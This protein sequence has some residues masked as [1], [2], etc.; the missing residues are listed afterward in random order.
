MCVVGGLAVDVIVE[1]RGVPMHSAWQKV[2]F[3]ECRAMSCVKSRT[4]CC[5]RALC[6]RLPAVEPSQLA[7]T[8][9]RS[10]GE[11]W[12]RTGAESSDGE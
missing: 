8:C 1:S 11:F 12:G 10:G 2:Y 6:G 5:Y 7:R 9:S 4:C 3:W